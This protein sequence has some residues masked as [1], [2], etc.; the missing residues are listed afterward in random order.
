MSL[1]IKGDVEIFH[2]TVT[3]VK[4]FMIG[5]RRSEVRG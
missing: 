4:I 5:V 2:Y 1:V 3:D